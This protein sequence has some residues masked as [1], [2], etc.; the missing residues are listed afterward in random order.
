MPLFAIYLAWIRRKELILSSGQPSWVGFSIFS[1]GLILLSVGA[2]GEEQFVLK[3]SLPIVLFGLVYFVEGGR[4]AQLMIPSIACLFLMI[5]I[6][7]TLNRETALP[8]QLLDANVSARILKMIGI[9][10]L[11]QGVMLFL[12][13]ITL[14][15]ADLCSGLQ[16]MVA[17]IPIGIF[18]FSQLESTWIR[19]SILFLT[20]IPAAIISNITR[21]VLTSILA[22]HFGQAAL[23]TFIHTL[24]GIFNFLLGLLLLVVVGRIARYIRHLY[25]ASE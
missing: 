2:A 22:F 18:Y 8:L 23:G 21:I 10:V 14:E 16:S 9:P 5:P 25:F 17:L 4:L 1:L 7:Y 3:L 24:S 13:Y 11:Q 12:P 20:I 19:R 6:P 15:V